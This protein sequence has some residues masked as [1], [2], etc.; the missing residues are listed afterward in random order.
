[1][2]ASRRR[3]SGF[4]LIELVTGIVLF[5]VAM[6]LIVGVFLP[7]TRQQAQPIYQVRAAEL[8]QAMLQEVLSRSFDENS[9]RSGTTTAGKYRYCGA[10]DTTNT[11]TESS[12]GSC[13]STLGAD[14]GE[15][16][17][18]QYD[19]VDD[20]NT[21]CSSPISGSTLATWQGLNS[22]LYDNYTIS[23]CVVNAPALVSETSGRTD[24]AKKITVTVTTPAAEAIPFVSYR[25]NY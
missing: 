4:T 2:P 20:F 13:S 11:A 5:A 9:D 10:I 25:S 23:V 24:V 6:T 21:F 22:A 19:D 1:M 15:S 14:A 7:M 18:S 8:G 17:Y 12:T 3:L 16:S